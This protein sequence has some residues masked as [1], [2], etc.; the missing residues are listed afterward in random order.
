MAP[1]V[2]PVELKI[3]KWQALLDLQV[4]IPKRSGTKSISQWCHFETDYRHPRSIISMLQDVPTEGTRYSIAFSPEQSDKSIFLCLM[5]IACTLLDLPRIVVVCDTKDSTTDVCGKM[6]DIGAAIYKALAAQVPPELR[7]RVPAMKS[8]SGVAQEWTSVTRD[9]FLDKCIVVPGSYEPAL[10]C[11]ARAMTR[12]GVRAMTFIDEGDK[13]A[14][15]YFDLSSSARLTAV[16][17][18]VKGIFVNSLGVNYVTATPAPVLI[19]LRANNLRAR[20]YL[21]S[22][23]SIEEQGIE[24]GKSVGQ[25]PL[26]R[27]LVDKDFEKYSGWMIPELQAAVREIYE[28]SLAPPAIAVTHILVQV[29]L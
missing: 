25:H 24:T 26:S 23:A 7:V 19:N 11:A 15:D 2:D 18:H 6:N 12:H 1:F 28:L 10:N 3:Q 17:K 16:Q 4:S 14:K 13:L 20:S 22:L 29:R 8:M 21:A 27:G 9:D 5:M